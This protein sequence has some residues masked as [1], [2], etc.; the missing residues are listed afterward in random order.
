MGKS[1]GDIFD[2]KSIKLDI[3]AQT[4]KQAF[5]ELVD[6]I[7]VSHPE[8]NRDELLITILDKEDK[9]NTRFANDVAIPH[10]EYGGIS[11]MAGAIG[12]SKQGIDYRASDNKPVHIVLL[13]IISK[14][15][16]ENHLHILNQLVKL[17]L[18]REIELIKNAKKE[19][20]IHAILSRIQ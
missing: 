6:A 11:S 4:K 20:E 14:Q 7:M 13:L 9:V 19:D 12:V 16:K 18:S 1:L 10:T 17:A 8:C 3:E 5:A 2:V 15:V